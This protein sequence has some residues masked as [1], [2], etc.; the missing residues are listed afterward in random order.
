MNIEKQDILTLDDHNEYIVVSKIEY[1]NA[2][3]YYIVDINN[4]ENL[5]FVK[6]TNN[7]LLELQDKDLVTN[8]IP[9]FINDTNA[10]SYVS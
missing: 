4:P 2:Y 10:T 6:E 1:E 7:E 9:L 3:Y 8:L 5:K